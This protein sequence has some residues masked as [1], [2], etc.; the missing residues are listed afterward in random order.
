MLRRTLV[1]LGVLAVSAAFA[2]PALAAS[3]HVRVEGVGQTIFGARQP[4]LTP[5][6]GSFR[7]PGP[8]SVQVTQ[9]GQTP[10]GAL[11]RASRRGEFYYHA[12]EFSFGPFVDRIGRYPAGGSSGW[13]YKVNHVSP[14]VGAN[15]YRLKA[16]DRGALVLRPL[17]R[18]GRAEDARP[19][20]QRGSGASAPCSET[21]TES[22]AGLPTSSSCRTAG[23]SVPLR[24]SVARAGI[25]AAF[26][27]PRP[28]RSGP[29]SSVPELVASGAEACSCAPRTP[30]RSRRLR[31]RRG[32]ERRRRDCIALG[33]P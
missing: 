3:V 12:A 19:R 2:A 9:T 28:A 29:R 14:P 15:A 8:G 5:V 11:E 22:R 25:G 13:V 1:F 6:S 32:G 23:A 16:G 27:R 31:R 33:H 18:A 30:P 20:T 17:R 7:T 4:L 24:A 10:F 26:E 21:T